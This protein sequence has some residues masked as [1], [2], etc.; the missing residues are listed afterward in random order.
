M[1]KVRKKMRKLIYSPGVFF[2]DALVNLKNEPVSNEIKVIGLPVKSSTNRSLIELRVNDG[3]VDIKHIDKS[4][5]N[6]KLSSVFFA[7]NHISNFNNAPLIGDILKNKDDF[8]G[9][10]EKTLFLGLIDMAVVS[11][12]L[13]LSNNMQQQ[14]WRKQPFSKIKN[15]FIIDPLNDIPELVRCSTHDV[16]VHVVFTERYQGCNKI[17]Y[18]SDSFIVHNK[19][20]LIFSDIRKIEYFNNTSSL[21]EAIKQIILIADNIDHDY[22]LPITKNTP[23]IEAIDELNLKNH[24]MIIKLKKNIKVKTSAGFYDV[25]K[26]MGKS[27]EYALARESVCKRYSFYLSENK[28]SDVIRL[29]SKD[30]CRLRVLP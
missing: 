5:Q 22:L 21:L 19:L 4:I 29:A 17:N 13:S 7:G 26:E 27:I 15:V 8:V 28:I 18:H 10:R 16:K 20:N 2:K 3:I 9:F 11:D 25:M 12:P 14:F 1:E 24:D 30:G 23:Y 6:K